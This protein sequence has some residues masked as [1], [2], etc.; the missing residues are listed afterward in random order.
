MWKVEG[1]VLRV[2]NLG[3]A[4]RIVTLFSREKGKLNAVARG[5][6]RI[7]NRLLS[8]TQVF[9]HGQYLVFPGQG[10]HNLSQAEIVH[11]WQGLRDDLEK[12][13]YASYITE[14]LDALTVE[15]D[16]SEQVFSLLA[17]TLALADQGRLKLAARAF[18]V[19][20]VRELGYE[21]ELYVCLSCREPL[22]DNLF[23]TEQGGMLCQKCAPQFPGSMPLSNG[24]WELLKKLLEWDF[25]KLTILHPAA[26]LEDELRK[27]MRKYLDF[28][29]EYPLKSLDFLE[30]LT[31]V[32][33]GS[34]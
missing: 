29:L 1:V 4:D 32:P 25:S 23:F 17:S 13:A 30:T 14:L 7:R 5:A 2:R 34:D 19:R 20:L 12:F 10:L 27:A 3:E 31:A 8:P 15:E 33:P 9:T 16:P 24:A 26:K 28:R 21:P 18:E 22:E 11:S 6:R